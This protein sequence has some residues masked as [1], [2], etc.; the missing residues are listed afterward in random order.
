MQQKHQLPRKTV[1]FVMVLVLFLAACGENSEPYLETFDEPGN[2]RAASDANV[3]G[4]I[5]NGVY[6]FEVMS[7]KLTF[8]TTAGEKFDDGLYEVEATQIEGPDDNGYGLIFR[9][10]DE[11]DDFYSFQISGDG[12]VWIG[13]YLNG[14]TEE[15]EPIIDE[16]W[17]ESAAINQGANTTN[18]LG[19]Q[20]E[21]ANLIFFINDQEVG[22]VTEES[23]SEGDIGLMVRTLGIGG[24]RVQFDN[25]SVTPLDQ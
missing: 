2:W 17:F 10:D 13:R 21:G 19:V 16:W 15:A 12:Y 4:D 25:F 18:K 3:S 23:F 9:V 5:V 20:A 14:G 8:W 11:N 1:W 22:R 24:V 6:D 7:D